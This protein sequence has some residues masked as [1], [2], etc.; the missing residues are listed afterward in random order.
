[1]CL[2]INKGGENVFG[3]LRTIISILFLVIVA[4]IIRKKLIKKKF[5]YIIIIIGFFLSSGTV[6]VFPIENVFYSFDSPQAVFKYYVGKGEINNVIYGKNSCM[7]VYSEFTPGIP[8]NKSYN[9]MIIPI[10]GNKYILPFAYGMKTVYDC[11]RFT[12]YTLLNS[13][14]YY[15]YAFDW[16]ENQTKE[17]H[18]NK[19]SKFIQI[20]IYTYVTDNN[21]KSTFSQFYAF[22]DNFSKNYC[23]T[24]NGENYYIDK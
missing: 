1:M 9:K 22:I 18:D 21:L 15:I 17:I 20:P 3:F 7:I 24:I 10:K 16:S 8:M 19:G 11:G 2:S 4:I 6:T 12:I 14:D 13:K 23:L 5:I